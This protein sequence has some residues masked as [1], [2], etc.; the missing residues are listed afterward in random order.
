MSLSERPSMY[1][2]MARS[3]KIWF[4]NGSCCVSILVRI[5]FRFGTAGWY[6]ATKGKIRFLVLFRWRRAWILSWN[7]TSESTGRS[8]TSLV[9]L[10]AW[11]KFC[12][13]LRFNGIY[14]FIFVALVQVYNALGTL[15][16]VDRSYLSTKKKTTSRLNIGLMLNTKSEGYELL[17][18][19]N[20]WKLISVSVGLIT[21]SLKLQILAFSC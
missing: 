15:E 10:V 18:S 1:C 13:A 12:H 8:F 4:S 19:L 20:W 3:L 5:S 7:F 17:E 16:R 21:G 2:I 9:S 6:Y 14:W 11:Q